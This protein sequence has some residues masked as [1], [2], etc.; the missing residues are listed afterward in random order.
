[1]SS[2]DGVTKLER[3]AQGVGEVTAFD[4]LMEGGIDAVAAVP[5]A[6]P[7]VAAVLKQLVPADTLI[8][9]RDFAIEAARRIED[10]SERKVDHSYLGTEPFREDLEHVLEAQVSLRH[11]R[12]REWFMAALVN[13]ASSDRPNDDDRRRMLDALDRLRPSHLRLFATIVTVDAHPG[14]GED[15][16]TYLRARLGQA[17]SEETLKLDWR[18]LENEGLV[19]GWPSGMTVTPKWQLV[20]AALTDRGRRF[21]RFIEVV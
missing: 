4:R 13:S 14:G 17:L 9:L 6:G 1:M 3:V 19:D 21:A 10:I 16:G 11:R 12:K 5:I 18:D 20:G 8:Y 15:T 2:P 7:I